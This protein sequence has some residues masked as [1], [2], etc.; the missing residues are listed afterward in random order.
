MSRAMDEFR[1][2]LAGILADADRAFADSGD[3][4]DAL[5]WIA[6]AAKSGA[7]LPPTIG[8]WLHKAIGDYQAG[9]ARTM[10]AALGLDKPGRANPRRRRQD[11]SALDVA[12]S[13]M[14]LLH[15]AGGTIRQA[16]VLVAAVTGRSAD[17]L[18]RAYG[19]Q[20]ISVKA[21]QVFDGA[22]ADW[23][24]DMVLSVMDEYPDAPLEV[25]QAKAAILAKHPRGRRFRWIDPDAPL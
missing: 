22:P 19:E 20:K 11:R 9:A 1:A 17:E 8:R 18:E 4:M 21:A 13:Q 2:K 12:L 23:V 16:S 3:P 5:G 25:Q 24:A 14:M 15:A 7:P 10:D 6:L